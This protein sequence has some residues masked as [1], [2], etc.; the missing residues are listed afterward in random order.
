MTNGLTA[1]TQNNKQYLPVITGIFCV[2]LALSNTLDTKIFSLLS[3]NLPAGIILFPLG[4]VFGDIL[5]EVYGYKEARK[6]IWTGFACLL[7]TV[8]FYSIAIELPPADF[9]KGQESFAATLGHVPRLVVASVAAYFCGEFCNSYVIANMKAKM[10]GKNMPARFVASTV[11]GQAV[12]TVVF[13]MI[14][15]LG[16]L[17]TA[18]LPGIIVSGWVFKVG[19]EILALPISLSFAKWLKRAEGVDVYDTD[20]DFNPFHIKTE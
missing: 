10:S 2:V 9:W 12:D 18:A 3:F 14:A 13:V 19:W 16:V 4:Y 7:L 8:I 5:T 15:F 20:T 17:P 11:V 6:V 1:M